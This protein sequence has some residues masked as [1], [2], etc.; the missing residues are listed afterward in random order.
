MGYDV[1]LSFT[2]SV[3]DA[4]TG[5]RLREAFFTPDSFGPPLYVESGDDT[6]YGT[7]EGRN[8]DE[9]EV[10]A[11]LNPLA[12]QFNVTFDVSYTSDYDDGARRFFVG[13]EAESLQMAYHLEQMLDLLTTITAKPDTLLAVLKQSDAQRQR[14]ILLAERLNQLLSV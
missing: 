4:A 8:C 5:E 6:V 1:Y 11:L 3:P 10:T 13:V 7:W 9:D 2:A 14:L 12:E